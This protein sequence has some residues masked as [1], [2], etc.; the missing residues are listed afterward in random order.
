VAADHLTA[1]RDLLHTHFATDPAGITTASS[2]WARLVTSGPVTSALLANL[3]AY[4]D[5]LAP[6]ITIQARTRRASPGTLTLAH[7]ALRGAQPWVQTAVTAIRAI[8]NAHFPLPD[9]RLLDAIPANAPP[10]R[11]PPTP[12]EP[13]H[14]L[15][16]R[17]P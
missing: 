13:V 10:P 17:I 3:A 2:Y 14:E 11:Q 6:W 7:L 1:G 15:R 9:H 8:G 5:T 12:G 4:L 16:E